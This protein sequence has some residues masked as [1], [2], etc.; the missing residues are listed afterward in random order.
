MELFGIIADGSP[1]LKVATF[2]GGLFDPEM[3]PLPRKPRRGR[4]PPAAGRRPARPRG[5]PVRG[6]P[7]PGR[8]P[9][10]HHLRGPARI[11]PGS[12]GQT[13]G[14]LDR[15]PPER[16]RR[17]QGDRQLLHPRLRREVHRRGDRG[18][19]AAR[20]RRWAR[21]TT[22]RRV[23][24]RARSQRPRPFDGQRPLPGRGRGEDLTFPRRAGRSAGRTGR[25]AAN[26][27][28]GSGVSPS[29]ASTA[30]TP[31]RWPSTSPS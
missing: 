7:R 10:R 4:R 22:R 3:P 17:A 15:R 21:R 1:P 23:R 19:L 29:P 12:H 28:T 27:P 2:D 9:P 26:W 8:A 20:G 24:G 18:P 25:R 31:T 13:R 5:R 16:P 11:P 30:W 14:R 6:L